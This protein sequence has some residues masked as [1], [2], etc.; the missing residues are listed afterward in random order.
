MEKHL[1]EKINKKFDLI[2]NFLKIVVYCLKTKPQ[3][4]DNMTMAK[5]ADL[6]G[7]SVSTVSKAFSGSGEISEEKREHIFNIAKEHGCYDK[8]CRNIHGS[9]VIAVICPEYKSGTYS[10]LLSFMENE[11]KKRNGIMISGS[12][13]FSTERAEQLLRF[14][15]GYSKV[16]G[17]VSL[18]ALP[19][20]IKCSVPVVT[21]YNNKS[22]HSVI[23]SEDAAI[24][25]AIRTLKEYGHKKIGYVGEKLSHS[26]YER[27]LRTMKKNKLSVD[28][29]YVAEEAE[30]F[31]SAG[32]TAMNKL[33]EN[34]TIPTAIIASYDNVAIGAMKSI[35]EHGLK[36]PEDISVVGCDDIKEASYLDDSLSSITA[37]NYEL[38]EVLTDFLFSL[39]KEK[40]VDNFK[41]IKISKQFVERKSIGR[42][43][44]R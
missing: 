41:T 30:R 28:N 21:T 3:S 42:A 37:Y 40:N 35:Y 22:Y 39:I 11:I 4:G 17:I 10:E 33:F 18:C 12:T 27:F 43:P 15:M 36:I 13:D 9:K 24:D 25:E 34:G 6:A 32:Y 19:E 2:L 26:R 7:V 31:E 8:Y 38:C 29:K 20:G 5:L 1:K 14:F 23:V 16:D 44:K